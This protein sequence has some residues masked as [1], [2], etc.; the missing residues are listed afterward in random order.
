MSSTPPRQPIVILISGRGSNMRALIEHSRSETAAYSICS[1]ISDRADAGGLEVARSFGIAARALTPAKG[2]ERIEY[3]QALAA[4]IDACSP[5]LIALAGFMRILSAPFVE[6]YTGKILNIHPSLL[7]KYPGLH[8]HRRA[9]EAREAEHGVT[10]HFV[11]EQLDGGPP[12]IQARVAVDT[13][14]TEDTLSR[15]VLTLEH[16]IYPLAVDWF[17]EGRL[18][19]EAGKALLD[20]RILS[21]PVQLADI[22]R[23]KKS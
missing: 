6:R 4:A 17:C 7:P 5:S 11:T 8:T 15:R 13:S 3:D 16:V 10:V 14:D 1:V 9:I 12:V 22:E 21:E 19:F 20:G 2:M 23:E 18:R